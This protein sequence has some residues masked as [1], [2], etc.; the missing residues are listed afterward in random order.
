MHLIIRFYVLKKNSK[1][2]RRAYT[3][4]HDGNILKGS[5]S[6]RKRYY[7]ACNSSTFFVEKL[8]VRENALTMNNST[9]YKAM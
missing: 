3:Q 9:G 5:A 1:S 8:N 7:T 6:I 4:L 2:V